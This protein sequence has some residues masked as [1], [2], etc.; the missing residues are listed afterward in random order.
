MRKL[1]L[2]KYLL[3]LSVAAVIA[4]PLALV[5]TVS[6]FAQI[7]SYGSVSGY[8]STSGYG[9]IPGSSSSHVE[10]VQEIVTPEVDW[11]SASS[12]VSNIGFE[13][14]IAEHIDDIA[15]S[16][17]F[18][19]ETKEATIETT[20]SSLEGLD[21][22]QKDIV[23]GEMEDGTISFSNVTPSVKAS[24]MDSEKKE[25]IV[26]KVKDEKGEGY[27]VGACL[28]ITISASISGSSVEGVNS[29][30]VALHN[31]GQNEI[32]IEVDLPSSLVQSDSSIY[33]EYQVVR[34]HEGEAPTILPAQVENGKL[35][36]W[37]NKCS[38]F[39]VLFKDTKWVNK[40]NG[41]V[42]VSQEEKKE[43]KSEEKET[44]YVETDT[45]KSELPS[46]TI[47][48]AVAGD[49]SFMDL[50]AHAPAETTVKNQKLLAAHYAKQL[51][52]NANVV[53]SFDIYTR[54]DLTLTQNGQKRVLT[55]A[56]TGVTTPGMIYAVIYNQIDG[57]Y[58]VSGVVDANGTAVFNDYIVRPASSVTIFTAK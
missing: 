19:E 36:F 11:E 16:L 49:T 21:D 56:N 44:V 22:E 27:A 26:Q 46:K 39:T 54:S 1:D 40:N 28:D 9:S 17:F 12:A 6:T 52:F 55:W 2:K 14:G 30:T 25:S 43:S 57:A 15:R 20:V 5:G 7:S 38:V 24:A 51:G 37:T 33:R 18:M 42:K 10:Q 34:E 29:Q 31:F 32:P 13:S 23:K 45:F 48:A 3:P 35:K 47:T 41:S 58:L 50:K 4:G 8:G 53:L